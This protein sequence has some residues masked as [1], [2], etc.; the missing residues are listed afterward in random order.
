VAG[1]IPPWYQGPGQAFTNTGSALL[2]MG[3]LG[4]AVIPPFYGWLYERSGLGLD[5]RG[6]ISGYY[7]RLLRLYTVLRV[8]RFK[9]EIE[10]LSVKLSLSRLPECNQQT[11]FALVV[12]YYEHKATHAIRKS[13]LLLAA[14]AVSQFSHAQIGDVLKKAKTVVTEATGGALSQEDAGKGLKEAL[15][16]G[17]NEA[18]SFLSAQGRIFQKSVQDSCT[19]GGTKGRFPAEKCP[20]LYQCRGRSD[21]TH[22]P[23]CGGCSQKSRTHFLFL[24]SPKCRFRMP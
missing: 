9:A 6:R 16:V 12:Q 13:L 10:R 2:I 20:R 17:V 15:N 18:V 4:R 22:E 19:R 3:I 1:H 5:F 14:L 11:A 21:R 8:S 24:P 23:R 7:V